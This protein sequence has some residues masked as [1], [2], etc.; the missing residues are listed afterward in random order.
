[1]KQVSEFLKGHCEPTS[2]LLKDYSPYLSEFSAAAAEIEIPGQ[3]DGKSMPRVEHHAKIFK[4]RPEVRVMNTIRKPVKVTVLGSDTKEYSYL[5]KFGEDLRQDQ[6]IQQL[7]QVMN[8]VFGKSYGG[9]RQ[10]FIETFQ[11]GLF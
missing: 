8:D 2:S 7:F 11:V 3:Y 10:L 5:V 4:F 9:C 6:R 1:M